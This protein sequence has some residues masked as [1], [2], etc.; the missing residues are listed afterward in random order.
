MNR[1]V[2]ILQFMWLGIALVSLVLALFALFTRSAEDAVYF[3][4]I[5]LVGVLFYFVNKRRYE[6]AIKEKQN[7]Q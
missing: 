7:K 1:T 4:V 6:N 3:F 2:K 5:T